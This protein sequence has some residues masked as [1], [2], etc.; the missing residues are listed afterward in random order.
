MPEYIAFFHRQSA[1]E[2]CIYDNT[3]GFS[4][5]T[6]ATVQGGRQIGVLLSKYSYRHGNPNA[7]ELYRRYSNDPD[8]FMKILSG[9]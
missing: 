8:Y 4:I 9:N 6:R 3:P 7:V 2:F 1:W 5:S